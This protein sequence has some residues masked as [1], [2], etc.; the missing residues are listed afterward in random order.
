MAVKQT[1]VS[2]PACWYHSIRE[3]GWHSRRQEHC[4]KPP[5]AGPTGS[6]SVRLN[7]HI[8]IFHQTQTKAP[9]PLSRKPKM[10]ESIP[11]SLKMKTGEKS[12][13]K[14]RVVLN[15]WSKSYLTFHKFYKKHKSVCFNLGSPK[16]E[17]EIRAWMLLVWEGILG[18]REN[19][20]GKGNSLDRGG[21]LKTIL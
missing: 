21:L 10:L 20:R 16:A 4:W 15:K 9:F 19:K 3:L 5:P 2:G 18:S 6:N 14:E 11:M 1:F 8:I 13:R 12:E 17:L 7:N